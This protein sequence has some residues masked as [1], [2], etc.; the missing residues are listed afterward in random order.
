MIGWYVHHHG[1]GHLHRA[2]AVAAE[3]R[4]DVTVLSSLPP[5]PWAPWVELPRDDLEGRAGA[6]AHG[7]LHF[8]PTDSPGHRER[9]ARIVAWVRETRPRLVVVDVS[10]EVTVLL[11]TLGVPVVVSA[12]PGERDDAP[13]ELGHDLASHI[14]APWPGDLYQPGYLQRRA[15]S[16]TWVGGISRYAGRPLPGPDEVTTARAG[17]ARQVLLVG[18]AGGSGLTRAD[19]DAARAATPGWTWTVAG[20]LGRWHDDLWPL[21]H[22]CD[23]AVVAAGQNSV[24]DVAAA[25]CR[26]I[27]IPEDRPFDEQR[28]TAGVLDRAGLAVVRDSWPQDWEATLAEA[29]D[30]EPRWE[31][32]QVEGAAA[33]AAR[34]VEATCA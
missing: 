25:G 17:A 19:L 34:A 29:M 28:A 14:V 20:P 6:T 13:H 27:V 33:R 22:A 12:M 9:L 11:R 2:R 32:W 16:V 4:E 31:R 7:R 15:G 23:V 5:E 8:A 24:A 3:L 30:R 26:A 21:L 18:G 10:V 1:R